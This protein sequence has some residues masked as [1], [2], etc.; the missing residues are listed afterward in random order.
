MKKNP[1]TRLGDPLSQKCSFQIFTQRSNLKAI[2][3]ERSVV[4]AECSIM[5]TMS[6][7]GDRHMRAWPIETPT[8]TA[9]ADRRAIRLE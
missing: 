9:H 8:V 4:H 3:R 5:D 1:A 2:I 6:Y 7:I